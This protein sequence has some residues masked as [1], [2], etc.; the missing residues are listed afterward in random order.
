MAAVR[1]GR[2]GNKGPTMAGHGAGGQPPLFVGGCSPLRSQS[3]PDHQPAEIIPMM[4]GRRGTT[5][6]R[7]PASRA[8]Y[9]HERDGREP[10]ASRRLGDVRGGDGAR[11]AL[12]RADR[13][14][15][16]RTRA[17]S[18]ATRTRS[19][20]P[21]YPST[22]GSSAGMRIERR[23]WS[24]GRTGSGAQA[25]EGEA[26]NLKRRRA[27][28]TLQPSRPD[29]QD[30]RTR[31]PAHKGRHRESRSACCRHPSSLHSAGT[32]RV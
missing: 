14:H 25:R 27:G 2:S 11:R 15:F 28:L 16:L 6:I 7:S 4:E 5:T 26:A 20:L 22:F 1:P 13:S 30:W 21:S 8:R 3:S 18:L 24:A 17:A 32:M 23:H 9:H 29:L 12:S 31:P 10:H 19:R